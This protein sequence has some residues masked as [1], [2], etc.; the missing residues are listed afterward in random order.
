M[1]DATPTAEALVRTILADPADPLP[2][3]VFADWLDETDGVANHAWAKYLRLAVDLVHLPLTPV[4]RAYLE[5]EQQR[6]AGEVRAGLTVRAEQFLAH[7]AEFRQLLPLRCLTLNLD[8][9]E[10]APAT[11]ARLSPELAREFSA[12]PMLDG[13]ALVVAVDAAEID[14]AGEQL[15]LA[16]G[17]RV[18]AVRAAAD[19][20]ADAIE[21]HYTPEAEFAACVLPL[22]HARLVEVSPLQREAESGP[23]ARVVSMMLLDALTQSAE[24]LTVERHG[25][26]VEV[27]FL[28][29]GERK[30]W[31]GLPERLHLPVVARMQWLAGLN[32]GPTEVDQIGTLPHVHRGRLVQLPLRVKPSRSGPRVAL[33]VPRDPKPGA[34]PAA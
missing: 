12:L 23:V 22:A 16:L 20:L 6:A 32:L 29:A 15:E 26:R 11:L 14:V 4:R 30:L 33:A 2:R 9:V 13:P 31:G 17:R 19:S 25:P 28:H 21:R 24:E 1:T 7:A 27:R 8:T 10:V 34:N 3:L 18:E 5:A